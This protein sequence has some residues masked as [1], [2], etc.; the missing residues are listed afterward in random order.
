MFDRLIEKLKETP[1]KIVFTVCLTMGYSWQ[2]ALTAILI[3]GIL[4][5]LIEHFQSAHH[6]IFCKAVYILHA[7]IIVGPKQR[8]SVPARA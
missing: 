1:R 8:E 3:E 4:F 6:I 5:I 7:H 2:F